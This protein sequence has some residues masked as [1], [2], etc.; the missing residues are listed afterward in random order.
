MI[1]NAE[2]IDVAVEPVAP[3]S[4]IALRSGSQGNGSGGGNGIVVHS[5]DDDGPPSRETLNSLTALQIVEKYTLMLADSAFTPSHLIDASN[6][7]RTQANCFR[8]ALQA[9]NWGRNP[10]DVA[11][12]SYVT[13][14]KI[15]YEGKLIASVVN[16]RAGLK[17]RL[18]YEYSGSGDDRTVVVTGTF[19]NELKPRTISLSVKQAR[20]NNEM[21]SKDPD[22]K[23]AYCGALRWARRH[24]PE[25]VDGVLSDEDLDVI[26]AQELPPP[27]TRTPEE[28]AAA[29]EAKRVE[30][31]NKKKE[32]MERQRAALLAASAPAP[33]VA[34]P[35]AAPT[36]TP[37]P[38]AE[39]IAMI[40]AEKKEH[41]KALFIASGMALEAL[42]ALIAAKA[43]GKSKLSELTAPEALQVE[44]ELLRKQPNAMADAR[45]EKPVAERVASGAPAAAGLAGKGETSNV[46]A[47]VPAASGS[48][49]AV[50]PTASTPPQAASG[51]S[52]AAAET[53]AH[54]TPETVLLAKNIGSLREKLGNLW[55]KSEQDAWLAARKIT[56]FAYAKE[57]DLVDL[58]LALEKRLPVGSAA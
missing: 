46:A 42:T 38:V 3:G 15:G 39:P 18:E 45:A 2:P 9:H 57:Q 56:V 33:A 34:A 47:P 12:R 48:P 52:P 5:R 40:T 14:G 24:C 17:G 49:V 10:F 43:P 4:E 23:L 30:A 31:E 26:A 25:V 37:A 54:S 21:W 50:A 32:A 7:R 58:K 29:E 16:T 22:Q 55:P 28:I 11:D 19:R 8:V 27:D 1:A 44:G 53:R 36:A 35:V 13:K 6:P 20:T 41:L 51:A